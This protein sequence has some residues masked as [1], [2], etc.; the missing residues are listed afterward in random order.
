MR[1]TLI[2]IIIIPANYLVFGKRREK[3]TVF[4]W[5]NWIKMTRTARARHNISTFY[6][7]LHE[8]AIGTVPRQ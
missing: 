1:A 8:H 5:I 7:I 3:W 2:I 6:G 4:F